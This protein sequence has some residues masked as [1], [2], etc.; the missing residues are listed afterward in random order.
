MT[1]RALLTGLRLRLALLS[2]CV[3][4]P[5]AAPAQEAPPPPAVASPVSAE[6]D[7]AT[8]LAQAGNFRDARALL[9]D[10]LEREGPGGGL[11]PHVLRLDALLR[12]VQFGLSWREPAGRDLPGG[13]VMAWS[14]SG[15]PVT[16]RYTRRTTLTDLPRAR[17][18]ASLAFLES[19]DSS[20]VIPA[21]MLP[22]ADHVL[23]G[24]GVLVHQ[25][26]FGPECA[27]EI[28][29]DLPEDDC[30][31][32]PHVFLCVD[33]DGSYYDLALT[34]PWYTESS[35]DWGMGIEVRKGSL[36]RVVK[37]T[38]MEDLPDPSPIEKY[39]M[40]KPRPYTVVIKLKPDEIFFSINGMSGPRF[41]RDPKASGRIG[42]T[43]FP[44]VTSIEVTGALDR[45][46]VSGM[47][48]AR[49]TEARATFD[50]APPPDRSLPAWWPG[51]VATATSRAGD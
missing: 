28:K 37:G 42:Y 46:W 6:V 3:A 1:A 50:A 31:L 2:A 35:L 33:E 22:A 39:G 7:R 32:V 23:A 21:V 40:K 27:L 29:G 20:P 9:L 16:L 25:A 38:T 15:G 26:R 18:D 36:R 30:S 34:W 17:D 13:T 5:A 45:A 24:N 44:G 48:S 43:A 14:E 49:R 4:L 8:A 10:V 41:P 19:L 47:S 11:A 51:L 12:D